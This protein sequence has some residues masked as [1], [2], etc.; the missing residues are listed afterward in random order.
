MSRKTLLDRA[1]KMRRE[2][3]EPER[4]L[5]M[6]LRGSRLLGHKFRR[7]AVMGNRI[8]DFFCPT[9]GLAV[10]IDGDTHDADRDAARDERLTRETGF[11][12]VRFTNA[13]VMRNMEGVLIALKAALHG[14]E[15]RWTGEHHPLTPSSKEEGG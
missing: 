1:A 10:E 12:V 11:R 3:T 15:D 6:E 14:Q 7:Q 13:D 8:V 2:P 4:R 5:W 9:K